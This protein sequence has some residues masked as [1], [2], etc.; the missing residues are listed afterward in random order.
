RWA[1]NDTTVTFV[2]E[3]N[4]FAVPLDRGDIEQLTDVGPRKRDPRETDSQ[5]FIKTEE[6]T[7]IEH[8]RVEAEKKKRKEEKDK[9]SG[10][11]KYE[12]ADR[13]TAP[14]LQLAPDGKHVFIIVSERSE[15]A[16]R[17]NVPNYVTDSSYTEDIP[18]RTFVGDAQ[19]K[20]TLVVLNLDTGKSATAD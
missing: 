18:A 1:R 13:Q 8:T 20:R 12:L 9:A 16:K 5:K 2:R 15:A 17:P 6:D 4:L 14:D 10:L 7:L 3:N 11:P 19:D